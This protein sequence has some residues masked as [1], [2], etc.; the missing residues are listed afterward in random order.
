[1]KLLNKI[2][3]FFTRKERTAPREPITATTPTT[4]AEK[5]CRVRELGETDVPLFIP[6]P[7]MHWFCLF[8]AQKTKQP[9][10]VTISQIEVLDLFHPLTSAFMATAFAI[11]DGSQFFWGEIGT[12]T[13]YASE[14]D[15]FIYKRATSFRIP[16]KPKDDKTA[17]KAVCVYKKEKIIVDKIIE[18]QFTPPTDSDNERIVPCKLTPCSLEEAAEF[19]KNV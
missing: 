5:A 7:L 16:L 9:S 6:Q 14:E 1:M 3:K 18:E 13:V 2:A 12:R 11:K 8:Q 4:S 19:I 10:I 17:Y 15:A